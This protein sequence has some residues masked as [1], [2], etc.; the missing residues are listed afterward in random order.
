MARFSWKVIKALIQGLHFNLKNGFYAK[1]FCD[2]T[3]G[4]V[5]SLAIGGTQLRENRNGRKETDT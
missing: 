2:L 3:R 1:K 5:R 4:L